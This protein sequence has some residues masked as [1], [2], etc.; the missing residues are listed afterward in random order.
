MLKTS[1]RILL[2]LQLWY[3]LRDASSPLTFFSS[4]F[5]SFGQT[6]RLKTSHHEIVDFAGLAGSLYWLCSSPGCASSFGE[7]YAQVFRT[8]VRTSAVFDTNM[9][10]QL[11]CFAQEIPKSTCATDL[12]SECLCTNTALNA[13]VGACSMQTCTKFELLRKTSPQPYIP[14]TSDSQ[15]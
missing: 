14:P 15:M 12:T 3:Y 13:A 8:F 4:Y 9:F 1:I 7:T 5:N 11:A 6:T 10:I 2:F